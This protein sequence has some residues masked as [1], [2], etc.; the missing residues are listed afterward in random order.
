[1]LLNVTFIE[2]NG[3]M[4]DRTY[5]LFLSGT[6]AE[7]LCLHPQAVT[8]WADKIKLTISDKIQLLQQIGMNPSCE[9]ADKILC[10]VVNDVPLEQINFN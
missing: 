1:M 3:K 5:S 7:K 2:G 6:I 9:L 8:E 4:D 10:T